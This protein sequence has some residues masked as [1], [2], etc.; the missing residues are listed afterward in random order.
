M[1]VNRS[2]VLDR[3]GIKEGH[4]IRNPDARTDK[5]TA[6]EDALVARV[7][8]AL[9]AKMVEVKSSRGKLAQKIGVTTPVV[10]RILGEN[11]NMTLRTLARVAYGLGFRVSIRFERIKKR[12]R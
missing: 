2:E 10:S 9:E 3:L 6:E 1:A 5:M 11:G 8:A 12:S 7:Q 4:E